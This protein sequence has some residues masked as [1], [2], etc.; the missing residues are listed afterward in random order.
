MTD[1]HLRAESGV[2]KEGKAFLDP[3][4]SQGASAIEPRR[5]QRHS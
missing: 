1:Y 3:H 2:G 4:F 5:A